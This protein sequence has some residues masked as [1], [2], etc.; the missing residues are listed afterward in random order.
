MENEK[1][2]KGEGKATWSFFWIFAST[3]TSYR[4]LQ[5]KEGNSSLHEPKNLPP[6]CSECKECSRKG[7]LEANSNTQTTAAT[8]KCFCVSM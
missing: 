5:P 8:T 2:T 6:F 1:L 7:K 3:V 4:D